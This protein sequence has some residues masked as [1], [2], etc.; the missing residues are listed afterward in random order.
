MTT[1]LAVYAGAEEA[2]T[3]TIDHDRAEL[4][5][6]ERV[7]DQLEHRLDAIRK[8]L[9]EAGELDG[10]FDAVVGRGGLFRPI[11]SGAYEVNEQMLEDAREG[12]AGQHASNLG[13]LIADALVKELGGRA[14]VVD[15]VCVDEFE[16]LA[17]YSGHPEI[18]RRSLIHAL[19]IK[20][21]ARKAAAKLG[22]PLDSINMIVAHLGSGISI[23]PLRRGRMID[24]NNALSGGPFSP[25][26]TGA[27]PLIEMFDFMLEKDYGPKRM[28]RFIAKEGGLLAY[29]GTNSFR[30]VE[31]R[32]ESGDDAALEVL[33]AMV[34][35]TAKEIGAMAAVLSGDVDAIVLTGA[36]VR[37]E[38]F[39]GMIRER[40]GFIADVMAL[41][42]ENELESLAE[43]A[44]AVLDGREPARVY[45]TG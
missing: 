25:E 12:Y 3:S 11:P 1:K 26:R 33:E 35:Q 4:E 10:S 7:P 22:K 43:G 45:P 39:A 41:P 36:L 24:V 29:L 2:L 19:N 6:F 44:L 31:E 18:E 20:A 14:F 30:E 17:R 34:Y 42:G 27:L 37:Y 23:A 9:R 40:V 15:P 32:V 38:R 28:K 13:A 5:A 16:P 8:T 21:T